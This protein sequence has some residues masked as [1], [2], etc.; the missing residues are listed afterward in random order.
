MAGE[1]HGRGADQVSLR[2]PDGMRDRIKLQ[3]D[4]NGRSMNAEIVQALEEFFPPEPSIEQVLDRVHAA[5]D[6]AQKSVNVPYRKALVEALDAL[7]ERLS[8][9]IEFDQFRS[10]TTPP[11]LDRV[12]ENSTRNQRWKRAQ[13]EGVDQADLEKELERGLL[14][15]IDK[16]R[17]YSSLYSFKNSQPVRALNILRLG[18]LKFA[19]TDAALQAI[20]HRVQKIYEENFGEFD[21]DFP[22]WDSDE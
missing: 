18:H 3:A 21:P 2:L 12:L 8:T 20:E 7:S 9:G 11:G 14:D 17:L 13:N 15:R 1:K 16:H 10:S 19:E 22:P 5:I 4:R 6:T